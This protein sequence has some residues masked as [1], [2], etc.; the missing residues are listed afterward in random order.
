MLSSKRV[1]IVLLV[2][3]V[4]AIVSNIW[5]FRAANNSSKAKKTGG[6][7]TII[8]P[9]GYC[10]NNTQG[11]IL[12]DPDRAIRDGHRLYELMTIYKSRHN[13]FAALGF[14]LDRDYVDNP[15][16]YGFKDRMDAAQW[17]HNPDAKY[18]D[19]F[20]NEPNPEQHP[21]FRIVPTRPDGSKLFANRIAGKRDV[22]AF[23]DFYFFSNECVFPD[24]RST[25]NPIGFYLVLWEDGEVT[26]V[27]HDQVRYAR[28]QRASFDVCFPGQAGVP[29][30][31]YTHEEAKTHTLPP[32]K[33]GSNPN[34][35]ES[36]ESKQ[37]IAEAMKGIP[38]K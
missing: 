21:A 6:L 37:I 34:T 16:A 5:F 30:A 23:S 24:G 13:T 22:L 14:V 19:A 28:P 38:K 26:K 2:L 4:L 25:K 3:A 7:P 29:E 31:V 33:D 15:R 36:A 35:V 10:F 1:R 9:E 11:K 17:S 8:P 12:G 32:N 27:P 18:S 20:H